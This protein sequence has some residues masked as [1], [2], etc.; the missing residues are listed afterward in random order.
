MIHAR[1]FSQ[2]S[3]ENRRSML[4]TAKGD[5]PLVVQFCAN[6]PVDFVA[7]AKVVQGMCDAV[8]LNLGCPQ[9]IAKTGNYGAFLCNQRDKVA[10]IVRAAAAELKVPIFCKIRRQETVEDTVAYAKLLEECG[11]SLLTVHGRT[12]EQKGPNEGLADWSAIRAVREALSIPVFANG[13]VRVLEDAEE[14]MRVTG[15]C[16]VMSAIGLLRDPSLFSGKRVPPL[17]LFDEYLEICLTQPAEPKMIK[18]HAFWL[19]ETILADHI[20]LRALFSAGHSRDEFARLS[21]SLRARL[22]S[23]EKGPSEIPDEIRPKKRKV[24]LLEKKL[25]REAAA[26]A[27]AHENSSMPQN[28]SETP[29]ARDPVV[30]ATGDAEPKSPVSQ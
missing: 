6:D 18:A 30:S 25:E 29:S 12:K 28:G 14:C 10:A 4:S 26:K 3:P 2:A 11:C 19:L 8:D 16:G 21:V 22:A 23:G 7:A 17:D 24:L 13:N 5:R 9:R 15:V 1:I 27:A 20:D